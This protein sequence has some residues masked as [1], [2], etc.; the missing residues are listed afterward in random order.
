MKASGHGFLVIRASNQCSLWLYEALVVIVTASQ[1][2]N[3]FKTVNTSNAAMVLGL[4]L[5]V[6]LLELSRLVQ[7]SISQNESDFMKV[8]LRMLDFDCGWRYS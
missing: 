3:S 1:T 8:S 6:Q 5:V 2:R 7:N 4:I